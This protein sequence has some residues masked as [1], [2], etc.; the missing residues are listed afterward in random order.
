MKSEF[1]QGE[2][3]YLKEQQLKIHSSKPQPPP[4]RILKE[5]ETPK[6]CG[7]INDNGMY[8]GYEQGSG[9]GC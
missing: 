3:K 1:K 7:W 6:R 9:D 5:G 8:G 4:G 2:T